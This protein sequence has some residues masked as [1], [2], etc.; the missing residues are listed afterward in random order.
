MGR[1]YAWHGAWNVSTDRLLGGGFEYPL[2]ET[3]A[4]KYSPSGQTLVAHSIYFQ[5]LGEHGFIGLGLFLMFWSLV[6]RQCTLLRRSTRSAPDLKWAHSLA[7][8]THVSLVGYA[9][10][11][12]FLNLAYW[13]MPYYLCGAIVVTRHI[14][15]QAHKAS[16]SAS[17]ASQLIRQRGDAITGVADRGLGDSTVRMSQGQ[18]WKA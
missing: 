3:I 14:V 18:A 1:I 8:M 6:W 17:V 7:S 9:V 11:G 5:V 16:V 13:D 4:A 10:G 12:A 15:R 2:N